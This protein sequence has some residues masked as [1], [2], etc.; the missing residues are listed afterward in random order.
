[1]RTKR[2]NGRDANP[3]MVAKLE[4]Y[5]IKWVQEV[6][7]RS[8]MHMN[9]EQKKFRLMKSCLWK[10]LKNWKKEKLQ[11]LWWKLNFG[12]ADMQTCRIFMSN[13]AKNQHKV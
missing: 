11:V 8:A 12:R 7:A 10:V 13:C 5:I 2:S 4:G 1:M 9:M 6:C 3:V